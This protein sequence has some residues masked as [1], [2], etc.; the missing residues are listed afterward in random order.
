MVG[1]GGVGLLQSVNHKARSLLYLV[2]A[3]RNVFPWYRGDLLG[4]GDFWYSIEIL[5]VHSVERNI[6]FGIV[7]IFSPIFTSV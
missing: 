6:V 4:L 1:G 5:Y 3:S 7:R 2:S